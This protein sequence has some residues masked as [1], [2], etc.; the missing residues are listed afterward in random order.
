MELVFGM[1]TGRGAGVTATTMDRGS[2]WASLLDPAS[3]RYA[4]RSWRRRDSTGK[5]LQQCDN[6]LLGVDDFLPLHSYDSQIIWYMDESLLMNCIVVF[7]IS[8]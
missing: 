6:L 7:E 2:S 8:D 1:R 4:R 5:G 3:R